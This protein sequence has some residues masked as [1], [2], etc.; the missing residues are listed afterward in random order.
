MRH[1]IPT[2]ILFFSLVSVQALESNHYDSLFNKGNSAFQNQDFESAVQ[3]YS[4]ILESGFESADLYYNTANCYYKL[5]R[6]T[7]AI[8]YYEKALKLHP[9][10][11]DILYNLELA[12]KQIVDKIE[13]L[14][15]PFYSEW[16]IVLTH[17]LHMDIFGFFSIAF[18]LIS[19]FLL[20]LYFRTNTALVKR[21]SFFLT[22]VALLASALTFLFAKSQFQ[23]NYESSNAIIISSR[24]NIYSAPNTTSTTL[25][26]LHDGLK[27]AI[28]KTEN[29]WNK[30]M[31]PDGSIGW[32]P[33]EALIV[34]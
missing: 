15:V 7:Q 21:L 20:L 1:I 13:T 28:L 8:L 9:T 23:R 17:S 3:S 14:P 10:G 4:S 12:N 6:P 19:V 33:E 2:F 24:V 32:V 22:I 16:W 5:N 30:I 11:K 34:I 29:K 25:F 31:L 26:I 18:M 27:V